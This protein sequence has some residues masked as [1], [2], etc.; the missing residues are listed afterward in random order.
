MC[1]YQHLLGQDE[2]RGLFNLIEKTVTQ[3]DKTSFINLILQESEDPYHFNQ[4]HHGGGAKTGIY[5]RKNEPEKWWAVSHQRKELYEFIQ[6]SWLFQ[7]WS[8]M[9]AFIVIFFL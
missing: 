6:K 7:D 8:I 1:P 2:I 9:M 5:Y 3:E 4:L